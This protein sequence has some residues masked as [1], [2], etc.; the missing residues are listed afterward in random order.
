MAEESMFQAV[1]LI[2]KWVGDYHRIGLVEVMWKVMMVILNHFFT[3]SISL[4][5]ILHGFGVG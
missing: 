2:P 1:V 3:T 5:R 4:H